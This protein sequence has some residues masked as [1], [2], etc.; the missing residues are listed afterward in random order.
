MKEANP[1]L[2]YSNADNHGFVVVEVKANEALASY[3]LISS[4]EVGFD[5]SLRPAESLAEKFTRRD[6]RVQNGTITPL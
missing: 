6:F 5:Y 2:V 4:K 1:G 3:H